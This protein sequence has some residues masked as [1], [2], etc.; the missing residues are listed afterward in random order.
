MKL[1]RFISLTLTLMAMPFV[2]AQSVSVTG[3]D[4]NGEI[5]IY[6]I[7]GQNYWWMCIE[8]GTPALNTTIT[9]SQLSFADAWDQQNQTRVSGYLNFPDYGA[10][11]PKQIAVMSYVL[12]TYLPWSTLAGASGRFIEQPNA[13]SNY[14]TNNSFY[15][16]MMVAQNFLAETYGKPAKENFTNLSDYDNYFDGLIVPVPSNPT[17]DARA[18]LFQGILADVSAK[19]G[20]D[21]FDTYTAQHGYLV[22]NSLAPGDSPNWQDGLMIYSFAPVPEPGSALLIGACGMALLLRRRRFARA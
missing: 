20:A 7:G 11:L 16:A 13:S 10:A 4:D 21:F 2:H 3:V 12:D 19:D 17:N 14:D 22:I 9:A 15:N 5:G 1:S 6:N 18:A 8:P